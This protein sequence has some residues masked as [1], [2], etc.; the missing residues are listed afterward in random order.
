MGNNVGTVTGYTPQ[1][2]A[3]DPNQIPIEGNRRCTLTA[4]GLGLPRRMAI[5]AQQALMVMGIRRVAQSPVA[6]FPSSLCF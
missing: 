6:A 5:S 3:T 2:L 1:H 4:A